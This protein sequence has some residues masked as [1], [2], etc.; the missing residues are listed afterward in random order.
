MILSQATARCPRRLPRLDNVFKIA[1]ERLQFFHQTGR[2]IADAHPT[3]APKLVLRPAIQHVRDAHQVDIYSG[4]A[5][6]VDVEIA[7]EQLPRGD[8]SQASFLLC[9]ANRR[10]AWS[11]TVIK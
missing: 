9:L 11:F 7:A 1:D 8:T 3:T 4:P 2:G 10:I 6:V 5:T